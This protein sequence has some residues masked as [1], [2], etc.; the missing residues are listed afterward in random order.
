VPDDVDMLADSIGELVDHREIRGGMAQAG[1]RRAARYDI[2]TTIAGHLAVY[3]HA[4]QARRRS[5]TRNIS[6]E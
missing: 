6:G 2:A 5:R 4:A 1:T 3:Q